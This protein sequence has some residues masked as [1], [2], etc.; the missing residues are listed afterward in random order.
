MNETDAS[1]DE[2][3]I[4]Q[5]PAQPIFK[6]Y[7]ALVLLQ[8]EHAGYKSRVRGEQKIDWL[9]HLI[10]IHFALVLSLAFHPERDTVWVV[11]NIDWLIDWL[12][13]IAARHSWQLSVALF[14]HYSCTFRSRLLRPSRAVRL[15]YLHSPT[16]HGKTAVEALCRKLA[17]A[18]AASRRPLRNRNGSALL[19]NKTTTA[20]FS[21]YWDAMQIC[22]MFIH[23]L[24]S[25]V[26]NI[27]EAVSVFVFYNIFYFLFRSSHIFVLF[28][29]FQN[30]WC[31]IINTE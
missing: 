29:L 13:N 2:Q 23:W 19:Q 9:Q 28:L 5:L 17:G 25:F 21:D 16:V 3:T 30:I 6:Y 7:S 11:L 14:W 15:Y 31:V 26:N 24:F 12:M 10:F 18:L 22:R 8:K 4:S 20:K 27:Q 1:R